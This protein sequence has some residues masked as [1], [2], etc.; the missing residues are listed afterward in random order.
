MTKNKK[1][2]FWGTYDTGKP[3]V[4]LLRQGILSMGFELIE[5]HSDIWEGIEDKSQVTAVYQKVSLMFR[6]FLCYPKLIYKYLR[7]PKHDLVLISYPGLVDVLFIRFF[8]W[9]RGVPVA[10]DVFISIYDTIV[11]DRL[12]IGH[13]H[14][15]SYLIYYL[16]SLSIRFAD[17]VFMDTQAHARRLE[18]LFKLRAGVCGAVWVGVEIEKFSVAL[19][20][21]NLLPK[22]NPLSPLRILF[23]GQ[24]IPLHGIQYIV[25]AAHILSAENIEWLLI[26]KGQEADH[27]RQML[28]EYSLPRLRWIDWVNYTELVNWID[29]SDLCLGIFGTSLKAANVI[30]NKIFQITAVGKPIITRDSSAIRELLSHHPP[31][32]YLIQAGNA[33]AL[34]KAIREH[35]ALLENSSLCNCHKE[36]RNQINVTAIGTQFNGLFMKNIKFGEK[37]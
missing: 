18:T 37:K 20:K 12:M 34:V 36:L 15:L 16:E 26:G 6:W 33:N 22:A 21:S 5:C 25:E 17:W 10:W 13:H 29:Y 24:F 4:R 31:C 8:A 1:I 2:V 7:L 14:P 3:R 30:P 27:I 35:M 32:V 28:V 19:K 23:Y 9:M 11:C